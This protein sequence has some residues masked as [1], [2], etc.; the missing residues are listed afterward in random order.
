MCKF[1]DLTDWVLKGCGELTIRYNYRYRDI[2]L[3]SES[4][5]D[6]KTAEQ[7]AA[8]ALKVKMDVQGPD[9]ADIPNYYALWKRLKSKMNSK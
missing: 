5:D 6:L 9:C 2:A 1:T 7:C 3:V 4:K 8:L